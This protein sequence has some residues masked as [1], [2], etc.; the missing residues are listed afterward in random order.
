MVSPVMDSWPI[1]IPYVGNTGSEQKVPML[2][3]NAFLIKSASICIRKNVIGIIQK[4][5][6]FVCVFLKEP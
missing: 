2:F 4:V 1:A 6:A 3:V 5:K